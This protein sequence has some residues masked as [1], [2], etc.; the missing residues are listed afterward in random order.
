VTKGWEA[1]ASFD[2]TFNGQSG[3]S[4][5]NREDGQVSYARYL[6]R[7]SFL[8]GLADFLHNSEQNLSLRTTL[9]GGYGR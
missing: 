1:G 2:S 6:N 5:T 3:A 8:L 4:K 7:N 9:G